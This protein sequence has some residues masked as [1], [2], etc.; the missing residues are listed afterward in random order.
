MEEATK[1]ISD[2]WKN[3]EPKA[4]LQIASQFE[5]ENKKYKKALNNLKTQLLKGNKPLVEKKPVH[6][7]FVAFI[8]AKY[9]EA[10][11]G[12]A[13]LKHKDVMKKLSA[14]WKKLPTE[15]KQLYRAS[16]IDNKDVHFNTGPNLTKVHN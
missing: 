3:L 8:K 10:K 14:M 7:P 15:T 16:L 6:Q 2:K 9:N 1:L 11:S 5:V 13:D 4:K 12:E